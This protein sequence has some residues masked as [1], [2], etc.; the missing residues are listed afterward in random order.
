MSRDRR[1]RH[2]SEARNRS[3]PRRFAVAL[4]LAAVLGQARPATASPQD[5]Q[6]WTPL[7]LTAPFQE[8]WLG[9]FEVQPRLGDDASKMDQ[10]LLRTALGYRFHERWSAWLGY[11]WTPSFLPGFR[12]ENRVYQQLQYAGDHAFGRLT[13]RTRLEQRWIDHVAGAAVRFRTM[14]RGQIPVAHNDT[15]SLVGQD[16]LFVNLNSPDAGP[17]AGFDQNRLF[18]GVNH[19]FNDHLNVDAGY[20]LQLVEKSEPGFID[21]VNH[22]LL[23]QFFF[24]T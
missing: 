10:L 2:A 16:E 11:A 7:Y 18:L 5:F 9:W 6:L 14:L 21:R 19:R 12:S 1:S 13:S 4:L 24:Q 22:V 3:A 15:W 8:R 20:Q 17:K 23:L